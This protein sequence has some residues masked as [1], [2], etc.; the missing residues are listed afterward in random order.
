[1]QNNTCR[2]HDVGT[3]FFFFKFGKMKICRLHNTW[4]IHKYFFPIA[5]K[6]QFIHF[7][8]SSDD[9][10]NFLHLVFF[11]VCRTLILH[12][13]AVAC[14][15]CTFFVRANCAVETGK[16]RFHLSGIFFFVLEQL[17]DF[18]QIHDNIF[19]RINSSLC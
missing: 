19:F 3:I 11:F 17:Y 7:R 16:N 12:L 13:I 15:V 18:P 10:L 1:M 4:I 8:V 2:S 9:I 14:L 6:I 5:H